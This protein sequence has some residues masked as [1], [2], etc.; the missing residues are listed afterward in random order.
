MIPA[1]LV[2]RELN[3]YL[4]IVTGAI[5]DGVSPERVVLFGSFAR[6][7]QHRASDLDLVVI[8]QTDAPFCDRIG[9]VLEICDHVSKRLPVEALVYTPAEWARMRSTGSSFVALV[10]REGRVLYDRESKP[11]RSPALARA[12]TP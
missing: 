5:V 11:H 8:A 7:D 2:G 6:G 1:R 9:E 12:G 10:E 3:E 4:A